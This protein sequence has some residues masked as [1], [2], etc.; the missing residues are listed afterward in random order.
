MSANSPSR[1]GV[2]V[3]A[4]KS[5]SDENKD[6]ICASFSRCKEDAP[7]DVE[8]ELHKIAADVSKET[9]P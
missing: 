4:S 2:P 9:D 3:G 6:Q 1:D 7:W 5:Y 8:R